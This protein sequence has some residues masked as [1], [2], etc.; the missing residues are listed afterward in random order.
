[1]REISF[2]VGKISGLVVFGKRNV[3]SLANVS[4]LE[5]GGRIFFGEF[6]EG[7]VF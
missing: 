7:G 4:G 5:S 2:A 3:V 1:M 6:F